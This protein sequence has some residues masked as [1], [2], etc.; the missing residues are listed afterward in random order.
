M[1]G[2]LSE[3]DV[4]EN[5]SKIK[6]RSSSWHSEWELGSACSGSGACLAV[7]CASFHRGRRGW[8]FF[9]VECC[10]GFPCVVRFELAAEAVFHALAWKYQIPDEMF[11]VLRSMF[12]LRNRFCK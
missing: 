12:E 8:C 1:V 3:W 6:A 7:L 4:A 11:Q 9:V 5:G 2:K 10:R